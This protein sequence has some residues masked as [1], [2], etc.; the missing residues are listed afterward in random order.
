[1]A[2]RNTNAPARSSAVP[3]MVG[4]LVACIAASVYLLPGVVLLWFAAVVASFMEVYPALSG[5][6]DKATRQVTPSGPQ[7]QRA[8]RSYQTWTAARFEL[9]VPARASL[10]GWPVRWAF[11]VQV[12]AG[13]GGLCLPVAWPAQVKMSTPQQ[14]HQFAAVGHLLNGF[15]AYTLVAVAAWALVRTAEPGCP[16][17]HFGGLKGA[18]R[19]RKASLIAGVLPGGIIGTVVATLAAGWAGTIPAPV[20]VAVL[21]PL[22]ALV[23]MYPALSKQCLT[24]WRDRLERTAGWATYWAANKIEP[25]PTLMDFT[26][27][28]P[29][30]V[31]IDT[32]SAPPG[33]TAQMM[34]GRAAKIAPVVPD[35]L[36]Y[37]FLHA[38]AAGPD[39]A[40]IPGTM[41]DLTFRIVR[42][43]R[44]GAP[45]LT[46]P[47]IDEPTRDA[48]LEVAMARASDQANTPRLLLAS[49]EAIHSP[50]SAVAGWETT[51]NPSQAEPLAKALAVWEKSGACS[52]LAHLIGADAFVH[53]A[54]SSILVGA[55]T[56]L[57][58]L[59]ALLD[60]IRTSRE[61][62][63]RWAEG[64]PQRQKA[65]QPSI[66]ATLYATAS[67]ADGG[68][69]HRQPFVVN[70]GVL[71]SEYFKTETSMASAMDAAS[72]VSITGWPDR[73]G[74]PGS[75]HPS[76]MCIYWADAGVRVPTT[77]ES[78]RPD[79]DRQNITTDQSVAQAWV[80]AGLLNAG[81]DKC[82]LAR[83]ELIRATC[84]TRKE[85]RQ[86]L[87]RLEI[88]LYDGVTLAD[89]RAK[90]DQLRRSLPVA[91]LRVAAGGESDTCV[92]LAGGE[93]VE[94]NLANARKDL[95][96]IESLSWEQAFMSAN[97]VV[98][99]VTPELVGLSKLK[100][101]DQVR[102]IEFRLP[103]GLTRERVK[104]VL[105]KLRAGTNNEFIEVRGSEHGPSHMVLLVSRTFPLPFPAPVNFDLIDQTRQILF[106]TGVDGEP[107]E[108]DFLE[109]AFALVAGTQGSGKSVTAQCLLYASVIAGHQVAVIDV[110]KDAVDFR[111]LED[112]NV[113]FAT[114]PM[115]AAALIQAV[116]AEGRRRLKLMAAHK[117]GHV[118]DLPDD[119]RPPRLVLFFD[120]FTSAMGKEEV[121]ES[122][123]SPES[124]KDRAEA[125]ARN[126]ARQT[127]GGFVGK[128]A[129]EQRAAAISLLLGT[130][131]LDAKTL[132]KVPGG[133][134][135]KD[136][137]ARMLL[138]NASLPQR[139]SALREP[140]DVPSLGD[141]IPKGRGYWEPLSKPRP[142]AIQSW[143]APQGSEEGKCEPGSFKFEIE[144]RA[145]P[146]DPSDRLD[147]QP[148]MPAPA[149]APGIIGDLPESLR[150]QFGLEDPEQQETIVSEE[151]V[152]F[153]LSDLDLD[154]DLAELDAEAAA[155][156]AEDASSDDAVSDETEFEPYD[157]DELSDGEANDPVTQDDDPEPAAT[158]P[159][160]TQP[161]ET[162]PETASVPEAPAAAYKLREWVPPERV[163]TDDW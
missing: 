69:I 41:A 48:L 11:P 58:E 100:H 57:P 161:L 93:P 162:P 96:A 127:L 87:W 140:N 51:W 61:W 76:G 103:P 6:V 64:G 62:G 125:V 143:F 19:E 122:D 130:Q 138:G 101:N 158:L 80:A 14:A 5:P 97:L 142:D 1:M 74:R 109:S 79:R 67:L 31:L 8:V 147:L 45:G 43:D 84:L 90:S 75:R 36:E 99:G 133:S 150:K 155:I 110:Q 120:E 77:F 13:L 73:G 27:P 129:R 89:V 4:G 148:F 141:H 126:K 49:T 149:T 70:H 28:V 47:A 82:K 50:E 68:V 128:I 32:F 135:I 91:F 121:P 157:L 52:G 12:L 18:W 159:S 113:G 98:D 24:D 163:T 111:F 153:D 152:E 95:A 55:L 7:E 151:T 46:D 9:F 106:A 118:K 83:P 134:D 145:Q 56:Q 78:L 42:V 154:L 37:T 160:D 60:S 131:K 124:A 39:G 105:A 123:G 38:P 112:H 71:P 22:G 20:W 116:Y 86:A 104:G 146:V 88:R 54:G 21:L 53:H 16:G 33:M 59:T 102:S 23:G 40:P 92:I 63:R 26:D 65:N 25:A 3:I 2:A 115:Q 34:L 10:P 44:G 117:V 94:A 136:N 81:F 85:A 114:D 139:M 17:V 30:A 107:I 144:R 119:V 35:G 66:Q 156:S 137:M 15:A 29:Q 72:F 132:D 108:M